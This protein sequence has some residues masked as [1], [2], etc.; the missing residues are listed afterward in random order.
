MPLTSLRFLEALP[1]F[2]SQNFEFVRQNSMKLEQ[3]RISRFSVQW[4]NE[5]QSFGS[6]AKAQSKYSILIVFLENDEENF[7]R[8]QQIF[9]ICPL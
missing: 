9:S 5:R 2:W 3:F 8:E 6:S 4:K 1:M 7:R